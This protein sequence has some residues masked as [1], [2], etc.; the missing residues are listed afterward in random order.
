MPSRTE[1]ALKVGFFEIRPGKKFDEEVNV[2]YRRCATL[3]RP[4][5]SI[6]RRRGGYYV[7]ADIYPTRS[8]SEDLQRRAMLLIESGA[9]PGSARS[10]PLGVVCDGVA[11]DQVH[12]L[13]AELFRLV[14]SAPSHPY[15]QKQSRGG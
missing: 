9:T 7:D 12:R 8:L 15:P 3:K 14:D 11:A 5:V 6:K 4:C 10:S 1:H 2:Y 13:A